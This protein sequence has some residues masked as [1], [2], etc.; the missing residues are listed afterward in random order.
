MTNKEKKQWLLRGWKLESELKALE[1]AKKRALERAVSVTAKFNEDKVQAGEHNRQEEAIARY[2]D[3]ELLIEQQTDRLIDIRMEIT[4]AIFALENSTLRTLLL[5][6]YLE[7]KP[8]EQIAEE[9]NYS[10]MQI[11]R[12]HG[13]ALAQI[14]CKSI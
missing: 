2:I 11:T 5:K 10:Y 9:M 13:R 8:W 14:K 6:R 4:K 1:E 3:Y 7:F 12:L